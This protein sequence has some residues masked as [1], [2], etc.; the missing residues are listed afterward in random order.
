MI[1]R[2]FSGLML[3]LVLAGAITSVAGTA[4]AQVN[5]PEQKAKDLLAKLAP[6]ER[7]GQLFLVTFTGTDIG[8]QSQI[9]DLITRH[10]V[11]GVVLLSSNDNFVAAPD[12]ITEAY[13]MI[14]DIQATESSVSNKPLIDLS[15][16]KEVPHTYVP[17]FVGLS[18]EGGGYPYDQILNGL[19]PLPDEMAIGASWSPEL[20]QK[21]GSVMG[22]ELASLGVNL[23]LGLSLDVLSSPNP[24]QGADLGPRVF[25]GDPYWVG[26]MGQAFISGMH[27]GSDGHV[28][29]IAQHFPGRGESDRPPEKEVAT[30]RKSLEQ[31]K[32]IELAPFFAVTGNAS[33]PVSVTDG[34]LVSHIRYQGF[35]GNIRAT[36]RPVSFDP[37]ALALILGLSP[38]ADWRQKGGLMV[39][40]D[41]GSPA[42]RGFYDPAGTN[43]QARLVAR[44][45]F[46]AG[47]DL[48]YLGN[49][50]STDSPDNYTTVL[51]VLDFF[52]QKYRE[53]PAFAQRVDESVLRILTLKFRLYANFFLGAVQPPMI[54]PGTIA[55]MQEVTFDVARQAAT[56]VSPSLSELD[57]VLPIVPNNR[58]RIVFITDERLARQCST[59][60]DQ[61]IFLGSALRDAVVRLYGPTS[62]GQV[63]SYLLLSYTFNDI[64]QILQGGA[65]NVA[66][67]TNLDR[68]DWVVISTLNLQPSDKAT[69]ILRRL[70][71]EK[72][73]LLRTK[74]V[75]LFAFGAPY[76]LDATDISKVTAYYALYSKEPPFVDVAA[77]LLFREVSPLGSLPVSVP[78]IGYDLITAT[79]PDPSQVISISLDLPPVPT[80][81]GTS[82]PEPTPIP[83]FRVGDTISVRTGVILDHNN[84][85]VPDG[86]VVRFSLSLGDAGILQ[87]L[88]M[89][90]VQGIAKASFHLDRPGSMEI[91]ATSEPATTSVVLQLNITGESPGVV[92]VIAP[93]T[94]P[95]QSATPG[96]QIPATPPVEGSG[97]IADG[98]PLFAGWLLAMTLIV[99]GVVSASWAGVHYHSVRWGLR[100]GL[101]V[102]LGGLIAYNYHALGL[103]GSAPWIQHSGFAAIWQLLMIGETAGLLAGLLW[104]R[105]SAPKSRNQAK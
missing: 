53:D 46:L 80:P 37:Q 30:V 64:E 69:S 28:A 13:Q 48:L 104:L 6:E 2:F 34:L 52:V 87:Q 89:T 16:G 61:P 31:L 62:G 57:T 58:D 79:S 23:Y 38:F 59:C 84:H 88:D 32:Q 9:Y 105:L 12:T 103:A 45:A 101:C 24:L 97:L 47:N 21:V 55:Q 71:T 54:G 86:T 95:T 40:D 50:T 49:I 44:D 91:R 94:A 39:S 35:Q 33:A 70:L 100:W 85:P 68:A 5:T 15:S 83:E 72:Q 10:H 67:E 8:P 1:R 78:G 60:P 92:T 56:L 19:T 66:V 17:L 20:A 73:E 22:Q 90:T 77:R 7:V 42:V 36:T 41:L 26:Q 102:L 27:T 51:R 74:R 96:G 99:I 29:V 3:F 63:N 11:G 75:V 98:R 65:G 25:G 76:Y 4:F 81:E 43:F 93:T 82:T 14:S 18:Q